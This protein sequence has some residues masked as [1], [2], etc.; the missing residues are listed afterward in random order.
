[1][2]PRAAYQDSYCLLSQ[3]GGCSFFAPGAS[4]IP[5]PTR[6]QCPLCPQATAMEICFSHI[7]NYLRVVT[8]LT[9]L[10]DNE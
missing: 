2:P 6:P 5:F 7:A 8:S 4:H 10:G 3:C 9:V 1:M